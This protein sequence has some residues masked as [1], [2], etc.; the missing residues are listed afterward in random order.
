MGAAILVRKVLEAGIRTV[1][2]PL[3]TEKTTILD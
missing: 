2:Y 1:A 3:Q